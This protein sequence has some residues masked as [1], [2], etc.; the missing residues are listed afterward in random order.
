M[1]GELEVYWSGVK[2]YWRVKKLR[3]NEFVDMHPVAL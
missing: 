3:V 2:Q 1:R